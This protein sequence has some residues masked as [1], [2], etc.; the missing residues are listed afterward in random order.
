MGF[1]GIWKFGLRESYIYD[2][3]LTF[4]TGLDTVYALWTIPLK[5]NKKTRNPAL[6]GLTYTVKTS[7]SQHQLLSFCAKTKQC[8]HVAHDC[9][10]SSSD[11][12]AGALL[13]F[14]LASCAQASTSGHRVMWA[15]L[16]VPVCSKDV[17]QKPSVVSK[18]PSSARWHC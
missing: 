13:W 3:F 15:P 12:E 10:P 18:H 9:K 14:F 6:G 5:Q 17:Q 4:F 8:L 7:E 2:S 16:A 1:G 11:T